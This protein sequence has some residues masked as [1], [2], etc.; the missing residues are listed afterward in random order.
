[1]A[2][3]AVATAHVPGRGRAIGE[4]V[5]QEHGALRSRHR[6]FEQCDVRG[7]RTTVE[8]LLPDAE[9]DRVHPEV[10]T[11][12]EL[13]A[14]QGLY[15]VQARPDGKGQARGQA[16]DARLTLDGPGTPS[17]ASLVVEAIHAVVRRLYRLRV[18]TCAS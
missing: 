1:M 7:H 16:R 4:R 3:S 11:V 5:A 17:R 12:E 15:Q 13:L 10:E 9:H 8:H 18:A 6:R 2:A 14:Q